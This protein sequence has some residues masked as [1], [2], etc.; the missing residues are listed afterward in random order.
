MPL[1]QANHK[2]QTSPLI[3]M[4]KVDPFADLEIQILGVPQIVNQVQSL[5]SR[6]QT[7]LNS[8]NDGRPLSARNAAQ[9]GWRRLFR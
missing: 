8:R 4:H 6:G 5:R 9:D 1:G 3:A 7:F 2:T